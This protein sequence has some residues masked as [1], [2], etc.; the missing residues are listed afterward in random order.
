MR[1]IPPELSTAF[2][3]YLNDFVQDEEKYA[4]VFIDRETSRVEID[5]VGGMDY[6]VIDFKDDLTLII[7]GV[8]SQFEAALASK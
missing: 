6:T 7:P 2:L 8:Y 3:T 1:M 4:E 5:H